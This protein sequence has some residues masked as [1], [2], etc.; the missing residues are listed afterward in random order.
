MRQHKRH[1]PVHLPVVG[2]NNYYSKNEIIPTNSHVVIIVPTDLIV[3]TE[4]P[5]LD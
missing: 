5:I 4:A 3:V 2:G 1:F